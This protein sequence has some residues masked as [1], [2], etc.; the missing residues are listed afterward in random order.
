MNDQERMTDF[1]CSEKKMSTNYDAFA[2][3]CISIP[4]RDGIRWNRP[5]RAR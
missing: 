1:I 5:P 4:L 2:S 3:E